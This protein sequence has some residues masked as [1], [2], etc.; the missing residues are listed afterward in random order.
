MIMSNKVNYIC[1]G[2]AG[3]LNSRGGRGLQWWILKE[4]IIRSV[5]NELGFI[6]VN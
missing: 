4:L 6:F 2:D 3:W 5:E 1:I